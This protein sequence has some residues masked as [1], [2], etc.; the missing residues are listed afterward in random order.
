MAKRF[1]SRSLI[2]RLA[3]SAGLAFVVVLTAETAFADRTDDER[4]DQFSRNI[5]ST[6][7]EDNAADLALLTQFYIEREMKP[8]W[9]DDEA[10]TER[11]RELLHVWR[12]LPMTRT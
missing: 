6:L 10:P 4:A 8:V 3:S 5:L 2:K 11:A 9:V 7:T 1:S 12:S